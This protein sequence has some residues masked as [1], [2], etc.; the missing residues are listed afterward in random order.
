M[1]VLFQCKKIN[2]YILFFIYLFIYFL[3]FFIIIILINNKTYIIKTFFVW[4][5]PQFFN[6][7]FNEIFLPLLC[8]LAFMGINVY[9]SYTVTYSQKNFINSIFRNE[10]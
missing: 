8:T 9:I 2:I 3:H 7:I 1:H 10:Y 4:S 5:T 6:L